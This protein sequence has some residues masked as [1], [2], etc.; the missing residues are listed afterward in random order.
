MLVETAGMSVSRQNGSRRVPTG[1]C[2][3]NQTGWLQHKP[4][5]RAGHTRTIQEVLKAFRCNRWYKPDDNWGVL[6][7]SVRD[8]RTPGHGQHLY[9]TDC[10]ADD[11]TL[12]EGQ[13][14]D[15]LCRSSHETLLSG[16]V[17]VK[18]IQESFDSVTALDIVSS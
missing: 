4:H 6:D 5:K 2:D 15:G 17:T 14:R 12:I 16:W 9:D 11:T 3:L 8:V 1:D 10:D 18:L 13:T 7:D